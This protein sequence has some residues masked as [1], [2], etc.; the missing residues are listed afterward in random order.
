[1]CECKTERARSCICVSD[2]SSFSAL[3]TSWVF[4]VS[5]ITHS[6]TPTNEKKQIYINYFIEMVDDNMKSVSLCAAVNLSIV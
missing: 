1:M 4:N 3:E 6:H 2:Y 5:S